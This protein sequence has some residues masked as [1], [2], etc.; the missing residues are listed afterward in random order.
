MDPQQLLS[1]YSLGPGVLRQTLQGIPEH[2]LDT[3]PI[4]DAWSVRQVVCHLADAEIVY[5]DRMK[6]ALV[7]DNPTVFE[8]SPDDS[9]RDDFC[10]HRQIGDELAVIASTRRH[11]TSILV[12]QDVESWQRTAVHSKDGPLTLE[13]L[14]ERITHHIPH[15]VK[16][17]EQKRVAMQSV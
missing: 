13:T 17:I 10:R 7:E 11:I 9:V 1:D 2:Q 6:R 8:W 3:S 12:H 4:V 14:L 5:A 15:H 16:F